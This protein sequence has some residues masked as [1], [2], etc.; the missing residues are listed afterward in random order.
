MTLRGVHWS[1][2]PD[3][4]TK[5]AHTEAIP[6]IILLLRPIT[7]GNITTYFFFGAGGL[8]LGRK[9]GPLSNSRSAAR[10]VSKDLESRAR[11]EAVFKK[12]RA[13]VL[14]KE[15][16]AID[17]GKGVAVV[18][19]LSAGLERESTYSGNVTGVE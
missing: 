12:F 2:S 5:R 9:T 17:G 14:R 8:F 10:T 16:N 19:G 13:D 7:L 6:N 11:I 3:E 15:A 4:L 18:L 1:C